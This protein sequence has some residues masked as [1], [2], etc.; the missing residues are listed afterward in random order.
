MRRLTN[1]KN[2]PMSAQR[3]PERT[4][5]VVPIGSGDPTPY[6][7]AAT[8]QNTVIKL[9]IAASTFTVAP[10]GAAWVGS[11]L[12]RGG[13]LAAQGQGLGGGGLA[14]LADA[15][16]RLVR[17]QARLPSGDVGVEVAGGHRPHL[18]VHVRVVRA[19][20]LGAAADVR[21]LL[22]DGHL[23][24][25]VAAVLVARDDVEL[26]EEFRHPERVDDVRGGQLEADRLVG[27]QHQD[28]D[29]VG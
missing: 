1:Q 25:V 21:A 16:Q 6:T 3:P 27:R 24:D 22:A 4:S 10:P 8:K 23:E 29:V 14:G 5:A 7:M 13:L 20:Q 12:R 19:A 15:L 26:E 11:V 2:P 18:E 9:K 28:G 17:R